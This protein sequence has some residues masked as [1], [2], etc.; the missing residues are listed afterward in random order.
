M[1]NK[2]K[3]KKEELTKDRTWKAIGAYDKVCLNC[4]ETKYE[5]RR[6]RGCRA[7]L[8]VFNLK[9]NERNWQGVCEFVGL[10]V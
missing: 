6:R 3:E 8:N 4:L 9:K 1:I 2:R 5:S 7:K 10:K